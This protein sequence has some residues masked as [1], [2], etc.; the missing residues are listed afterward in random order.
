MET[1]ATIAGRGN[2]CVSGQ[3]VRNRLWGAELC[4][5][6]RRLELL[7]WLFHLS[8]SAIWLCI[9]QDDAKPHVA[10]VCSNSQQTHK[11]DVLP[12]SAFSPNLNPTEY[13]GDEL[14]KWVSTPSL[15]TNHHP[16]FRA[17]FVA[18]IV[19]SLP[20]TSLLTLWHNVFR[21][22]LIQTEDSRKIKTYCIS[23]IKL[24]PC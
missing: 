9:V 15:S 11:V 7:L 2:Q 8:I 19:L 12:W 1:A 16:G 17:G 20:S 13:L 5:R 4:A 10:R 18:G 23:G 3:T 21:L 6:L 14:G 24:L 22:Q